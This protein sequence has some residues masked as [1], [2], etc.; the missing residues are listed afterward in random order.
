MNLNQGVPVVRIL[1]HTVCGCQ[2]LGVGVREERAEWMGWQHHST[3]DHH[4]RE[5]NMHF[6]R[7]K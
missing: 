3:H 2:D 7:S 1:V 5:L 6:R 4:L